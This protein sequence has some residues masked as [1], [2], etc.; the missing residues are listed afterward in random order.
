MTNSLEFE[1]HEEHLRGSL[2]ED[3]V[4]RDVTTRSLPDP[5]RPIRGEV[6]AREPGVL[7]GT[8]V[9][10]WVFELLPKIDPSLPPDEIDVLT[11]IDDGESVSPGDT[12]GELSGSART[13]LSGERVALNYLQQ[14]SGVATKT[15]RLVEVADPHGVDVHDTRKTVP[16]GRKLQK[17]AV[18][19]GGGHNHRMDLSEAVMVK[20]NHKA[21]AGGLRNY[22]ENLRTDRPVI[23]EVHG[24]NELEVV[25]EFL[26]TTDAFDIEII[27]LDNFQSSEVSGVA[28]T[29]PDRVDLEI[30][31]G[32][33][34]NNIERYCSS[35]VDRVSVGALTHSF[36]SLDLS[37]TVSSLPA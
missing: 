27:M 29:V 12:V 37:L 5:E 25:D 11:P 14:L 6:V 4:D 10:R 20:D 21:T 9:F 19:C 35:G 1:E 28:G 32:I 26:G 30:S 17:Y 15:R 18:R 2:R 22:L 16:H 33:D 24:T 3:A 13:V 8:Q 31:G 36:D 23:V 34:E 7:A